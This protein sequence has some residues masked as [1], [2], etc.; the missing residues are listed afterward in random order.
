VVVPVVDE[1]PPM[2]AAAVAS[3]LAGTYARI[4]VV[5]AG[6]GGSGAGALVASLPPDPRLRVVDV[7]GATD[8][9][10]SAEPAARRALT[11]RLVAAA[12]DAACGPW[13]APLS[14]EL[15]FTPDHVDVLLEVA[16][17]HGLELV[18][19]QA[20]IEAGAGARVVLG[21]WPPNA[22]GVLA[23]GSELAHAGLVQVVPVDPDAWRDGDAPG[24]AWWSALLAAGVRAAGIEHPVCQARIDAADEVPELVAT[25]A[26]PR[27]AAPA[28]RAS[29][30]TQG[31]RR[32]GRRRR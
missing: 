8:G 31:N 14:P 11:G 26:G 30:H 21:A 15:P 27:S 7:D 1:P 9:L 3:A 10:P 17:E 2:V 29:S 18:Y 28:R 22:D 32:H 13:I 12:I 16:V 23:F 19:G 4:E 5:V 6:T 20:V 25:A 24:W